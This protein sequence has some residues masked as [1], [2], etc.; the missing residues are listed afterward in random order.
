[1][2][3]AHLPPCRR[4][5]ARSCACEPAQQVERAV[6]QTAPDLHGDCDQPHHPRVDELGVDAGL[7][8]FSAGDSDALGTRCRRPCTSRGL[9]SWTSGIRR[10]PIPG[11]GG[12]SAALAALAVRPRA[13]APRGPSAPS[14]SLSA[15][16]DGTPLAMPWRQPRAHQARCGE[17]GGAAVRAGT[18]HALARAEW[19]VA[20]AGCGERRGRGRCA[21]ACGA[22]PSRQGVARQGPRLFGRPSLRRP[23]CAEPAPWDK[24]WLRRWSLQP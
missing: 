9:A 17:P 23:A 13:V 18:A 21:A 1:M 14:S 3:H 22:R 8:A 15:F 2:R 4:R 10:R 5:S 19:A 7:V 12:R 20:A 16:L 24:S 11:A 6:A